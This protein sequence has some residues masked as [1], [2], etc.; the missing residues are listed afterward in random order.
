MIEIENRKSKSVRK[1]QFMNDLEKILFKLN[2]WNT[3]VYAIQ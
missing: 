3:Q 2:Q 1:V